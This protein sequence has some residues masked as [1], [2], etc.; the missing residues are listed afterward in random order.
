MMRGIMLSHYV[1]WH[2]AEWHYGEWHFDDVCINIL[3]GIMLSVIF[4]SGIILSVILKC[5]IMLSDKMLG[6]VGPNLLL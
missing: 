4:V 5:G 1:E 3:S 6:V 2:Y